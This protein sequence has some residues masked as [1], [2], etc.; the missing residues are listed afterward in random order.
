MTTDNTGTRRFPAGVAAI[1]GLLL[2]ALATFAITGLA[3][4]DRLQLPPP[5]HA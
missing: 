1:A 2:G 5:P 3:L 4:T